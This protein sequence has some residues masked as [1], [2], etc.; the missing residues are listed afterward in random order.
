MWTSEG[1]TYKN[2]PVEMTH[3]FDTF[4]LV[5]P[6]VKWDIVPT[7]ETIEYTTKDGTLSDLIIVYTP[8]NGESIILKDNQTNLIY[9]ATDKSYRYLLPE[10]R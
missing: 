5:Q 3:T 6:K 9:R 2:I 8:E 1:E 4:S 10:G 7:G